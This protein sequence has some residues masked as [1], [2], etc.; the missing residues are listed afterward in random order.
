M[1]KVSPWKGVVHF[2]KKGKLA[3]S[4]GSTSGIRAK[5]VV[6]DDEEASE[7]S[8]KQ[9]RM[10]EEID[11]DAGVTLLK[12]MFTLILEE[13]GQLVLAVANRLFSTAEESV[14]TAGASMPVSMVQEVNI[15]IPSP[16][17]I[18]DKAAVGL[19][20]ELDEE[21]RQ[22]MAR[23][24]ETAQYFTEEEWKN[25]RA[26][27]EA[28]EELSKRLQVVERNKY[29]EVDQAKMLVDLINQRKKYFVA[30]K[31]KA[32]RNKPMTQA[33]QRNYM[34]NCIKHMGSHT[35]QQLK[36]YS[37]N[38]LKELFETTMK[39]VNTFVPMETKDRGRASELAAG[40]SQ[41]TIT[42]STEVGRSVQE[43][44]DEEEKELSQ[45]DLQQMMMVVSV[46]EVYV[47]SLQVKY[48]IIDW[49]DI[50]K[51]FDRDDLVMLWNL[52][53]ERFSLTEPTDNKET[54]LWVE[55]KRLFEP[56]TDDTL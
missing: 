40:S 2:G 36:R 29:S 42:D 34:I 55:L 25:I 26:R 18:K 37:F 27:V 7:D 28:D 16:V 14:S 48:P 17:V 51:I 52:V 56:N 38:E 19:L 43:Q 22:R 32:K 5:I 54:I 15:N 41:A 50:L 44:P 21:E 23:V 39:N 47:E 8:S 24:H 30:H 13:E 20:E 3:P 4:L 9:G 46:E 49:E 6:S 53:K 11:Q 1:L 33:Q 31:A 10:I 35:L 12:Q 45:E